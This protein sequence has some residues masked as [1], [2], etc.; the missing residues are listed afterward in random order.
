MGVDELVDHL[1]RIYERDLLREMGKLVKKKS[2]LTLRLEDGDTTAR[3]AYH[4]P[5]PKGA[6]VVAFERTHRQAS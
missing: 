2:R 6:E 3:T 4:I 1:K 5:R